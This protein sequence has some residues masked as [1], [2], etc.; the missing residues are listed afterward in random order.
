MNQVEVILDFACCICDHPVSVT[1]NC[2]GKGLEAESPPVAAAY[3][4][5][6]NCGY[7]NQL[8]FEPNGTVRDVVP[9]RGLRWLPEPSRN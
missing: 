7:V 9:H 4:P 1:V 5:C 6:P 2:S 8:S 3:V